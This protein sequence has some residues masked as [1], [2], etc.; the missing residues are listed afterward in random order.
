VWVRKEAKALEVVAIKEESQ[1]VYVPT[2]DAVE[3]MQAKKTEADIVIA[4]SGSLTETSRRSNCQLSVGLT[5]PFGR[6]DRQ[7]TAGLTDPPG[8]SDRRLAAGLTGPRG[9][10]DR[11]ASGASGRSENSTG[12]S[13]STGNIKNHHLARGKQPQPKWIPS[14]LS[15]SQK[16]RLQHLQAIGQ[17]KKKAK[18]VENKPCNNLEP[19]TTSKRVWRPK[20]VRVERPVISHRSNESNLI[21]EE[22]SVIRDKPPPHDA[23]GVGAVFVLPSKL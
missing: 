20:E 16:R 18:D 12:S 13:T 14:G 15:H 3:T 19:R 8:R 11:G 2:G 6:S 5:E 22:S 7:L 17:K 23:M 21:R 1:D 10:S 4:K 9:R